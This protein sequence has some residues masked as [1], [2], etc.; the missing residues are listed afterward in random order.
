MKTAAILPVKRIDQAKQRLGDEIG[1]DDRTTLARAMLADVLLALD[2]AGS[3][4]NVILVTSEPGVHTIYES[5]KILVIGDAVEAGQSRAAIAGLEKAAAL[6]FRQALL[7][8]GNCPLMDPAKLDRL[9]EEAAARDLQA[10][11]VPDRHREGTNA[12]LVRLPTTLAPQFGPRSLERHEK[13]AKRR[14]L[15][16]VIEAVDS[17]ALDVDTP[18]DLRALV[19]ALDRKPFAAPRAR[20][21][22]RAALPAGGRRPIPAG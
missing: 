5:P 16:F 10:V 20:A 3:M 22:I 19:A 12:L 15:R 18:D 1:R 4:E 14:G 6:G 17:L 8:P 21:G 2:A 7:I 9:I 11:I 13:Q